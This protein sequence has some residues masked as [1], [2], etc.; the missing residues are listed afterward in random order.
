[1]CLAALKHVV[2]DDDP[3]SKNRILE[4]LKNILS[5]G[6]GYIDKSA[7]TFGKEPYGIALVTTPTSV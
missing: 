6:L 2:R 4:K 1:M 5:T 7:I 3:D